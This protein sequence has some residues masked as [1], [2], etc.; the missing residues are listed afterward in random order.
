MGQPTWASIKPRPGGWVRAAAGPGGTED[1]SAYD[2]RHGTWFVAAALID[3]SELTLAAELL[4]AAGESADRWTEAAVLSSRAKLALPCTVRAWVLVRLA[5]CAVQGFGEDE[6]AG[7]PRTSCNHHARLLPAN[8][9]RCR[10]RRHTDGQVR[11]S[12]SVTKPNTLRYPRSHWSRCSR[13]RV[14]ASGAS[15]WPGLSSAHSVS[16]PVQDHS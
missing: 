10:W 9:V 12:T 8:R 11:R 13:A 1:I 6:P 15:G 7:S 14:S 5:R 2:D 3:Y 16:E 4:S